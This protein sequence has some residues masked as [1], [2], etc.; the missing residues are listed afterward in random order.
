MWVYFS[1]V[2]QFTRQRL[3]KVQMVYFIYIH[4]FITKEMDVVK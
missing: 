1:G 4:D 3:D 2:F